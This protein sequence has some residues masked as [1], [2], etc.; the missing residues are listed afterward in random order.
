MDE[1]LD[2]VLIGDPSGWANTDESAHNAIK[3]TDEGYIKLRC[4]LEEE[5]ASEVKVKFEITDTGIGISPANQKKIFRPFAQADSFISRKYGG[6]GL[7]L[8]ICKNL[9]EMQNGNLSVI[10]REGAGTTFYFVLHIKKVR[11][12]QAFYRSGNSR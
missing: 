6:T 11:D 8:T 1:E 10:S 12:R 4:L 7:G 3:F 2:K 9:V 5:T